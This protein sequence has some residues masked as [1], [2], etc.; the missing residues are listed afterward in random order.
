L[1]GV[2][3]DAGH[4]PVVP[5]AA[6]TVSELQSIARPRRTMNWIASWFPLWL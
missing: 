6:S 1:G 2:D 4:G 3:I 5:G